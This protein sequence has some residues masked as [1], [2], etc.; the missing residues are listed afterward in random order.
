MQRAARALVAAACSNAAVAR[1][2]ASIITPLFEKNLQGLTINDCTEI[3]MGR[4]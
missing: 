3:A 4:A 1:A 2:G